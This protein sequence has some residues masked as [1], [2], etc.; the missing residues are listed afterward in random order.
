MTLYRAPGEGHV[1][2][3]GFGRTP[4]SVVRIKVGMS[5]APE[6]R[7]YAVSRQSQTGLPAVIDWISE[8]HAGYRDN[9]TR[10]LMWC[11]EQYDNDYR[12]WSPIGREWFDGLDPH[13]VI[14]Y[15]KS[16]PM[17]RAASYVPPERVPRLPWVLTPTAR[18][19]FAE[20]AEG[21]PLNAQYKPLPRRPAR[22][23]TA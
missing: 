17:E 15:G 2:V 22:R 18:D 6:K 14:E 10:L 4:D 20:H 16:L 13:A 3:V 5:T 12:N 9:E 1:Y 19:I 21:S 23:R 8:P 7:V 11:A